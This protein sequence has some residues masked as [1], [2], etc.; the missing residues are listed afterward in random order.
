MAQQKQLTWNEMRL[1]LFVLVGISLVVVAVFYVTS[2]EN[3]LANKYRLK[4]YFPEVAGL[5]IGAPVSLDGIDVGNVEDIQINPAIGGPAAD[6]TRNIIV[7]LHLSAKYAKNIRTDSI[8]SPETQGLL[9]DRFVHITRGFTGNELKDGEELTGKPNPGI[10]EL[11]AQ[12]TELEAHMNGLIDNVQGMVTDVRD[13]KGTLGQLATNRSAY[14]HFDSVAKNLDTIVTN[15]QAGQGTLGQLYATDTL[16]KKLD[17]ALDH[18]NNVLDAIQQQKGAFGKFI[19]DPAIHD[20]A[21]QFLDKGNGLL[22]DVKNGKGTLSKLLYDDS[23]FATYKQAGT[24]L[25][26]ATAKLDANEGTLGKM[27]NDPKLYDNITGLT[28]DLRLFM[29]EFQKNPKKYL[30]IQLKIF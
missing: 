22:D 15:V 6:K 27:F 16:H 18:T 11:V 7:T 17:V 5:A 21:R 29:T 3:P 13:G 10:D 8:A 1:G 24:N 9:G 19:Y 25:A 30:S 20:S 28:G 14:D 23:L 4:T 2:V 12:G 26:N